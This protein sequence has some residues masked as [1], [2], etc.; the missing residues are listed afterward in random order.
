MVSIS[1]R[2][3]IVAGV[4]FVL[5][6]GWS[7]ASLLYVISRDDLALTFLER[8]TK[9]KRS[10]ED[11][12]ETLQA[13]LDR[14]SGKQENERNGLETRLRDL[15][16]RQDAFEA[17]Q[18]VVHHL[19]DQV[20][21]GQVGLSPPGPAG[22]VQVTSPTSTAHAYAPE[23][24]PKVPTDDI[25]QLRLRRTDPETPDRRSHR[26]TPERELNRAETRLDRFERQQVELL[27]AV[28]YAAQ[29]E[30][31]HL[32]AAI[33]RTGV[34]LTALG[35]VAD[36]S[37]G[38]LVPA[39]GSGDFHTLA[40][41]AQENIDHLLVLRRAMAALPF[42]EPI[43]GEID[44]SSGFGYRIDPFTRSPAL[45]TGLDFRAEH[46]AAVRAA[47]AGR[48]VT[49]ESSG[50][51][52][53]MVEI[54]HGNGVTTRYAHLSAITVDAGERVE[55]GTKI[56]HVGSTGRSTGPHLHY[57][58]RISGE[59]VNPHRFLTAGFQLAASR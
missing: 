51:Y 17:R 29:T 58:I 37:G 18:A 6:A 27:G 15:L 11:R 30:A 16:A 28:A 47:G 23:P 54:D 50:A 33:R 26:A 14:A 45:H 22:S 40:A 5:L 8:Q 25:F 59:P 13:Q 35:P 55:T 2:T 10:Y 56:G 42:G 34:E 36:S 39:G 46:G 4:T 7:G 41:Q 44:F 31:M 38:P 43:D 21:M 9:L 53:N 12:L 1:R 52:G 57:E 20:G 48:V 3:A 49:A 24:K 19:A 32:Q